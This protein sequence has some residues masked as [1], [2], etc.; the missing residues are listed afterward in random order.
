MSEIKLFKQTGETIE[1]LPRQGSPLERS[2][3]SLFGKNLET[4][5]GVRFLESEFVTSN[6]GRMDTLG[7]DENGFPVIIVI[8]M[9]K[10]LVKL[11]FK[12]KLWQMYG[13]CF[14]LKVAVEKLR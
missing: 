2:L 10:K 4:L 14:Q 13:Q 1:E 7:I 5:L 9:G 12:E 11:N 8:T 3:Q 6:R